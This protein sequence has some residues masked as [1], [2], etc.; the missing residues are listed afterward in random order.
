MDLVKIAGFG[1]RLNYASFNVRFH[2]LKNDM[3]ASP[4]S[5]LF[6]IFITIFFVA[7]IIVIVISKIIIIINS[8]GVCHLSSPLLASTH[9][10][11]LLAFP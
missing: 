7:I 11:A 5:S 4:S 1:C 10:S 8:I 6:D 3:A 2:L 9:D